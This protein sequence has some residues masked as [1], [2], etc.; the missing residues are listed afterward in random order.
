MEITT[1]ST[2]WSTRDVMEYKLYVEYGV[3][4]EYTDAMECTWSK[5]MP[6]NTES[7]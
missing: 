6:W 1:K 7:K 4:M 2:T 5:G 3:L